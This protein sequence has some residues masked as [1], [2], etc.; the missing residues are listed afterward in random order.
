[1]V[2][3]RYPSWESRDAGHSFTPSLL[4]SFTHSKRLF[5]QKAARDAFL[6]GLAGEFGQGQRRAGGSR[7]GSCLSR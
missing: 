3:D 1:M 2:N 5:N 4:H 6:E 7:L